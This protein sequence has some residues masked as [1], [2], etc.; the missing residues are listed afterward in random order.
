M[1]GC[2]AAAR[3]CLLSAERDRPGWHFTSDH[4]I[5]QIH[6]SF[7]LPPPASK[8]WPW[9]IDSSK[10]CNS[11]ASVS[12]IRCLRQQAPHRHTVPCALSLPQSLASV[13]QVTIPSRTRTTMTEPPVADTAAAA[14]QAAVGDA[15]KRHPVV[16]V[17]GG[18]WNMPAYFEDDCE[19]RRVSA[20]DCT[21]VG[22]GFQRSP[23]ASTCAYSRA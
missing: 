6:R 9:I 4:H 13:L 5:L 11:A 23:D 17:H 22:W 1:R 12:D 7:P 3:Q 20:R 16:L 18:A 2:H 21:C 14:E 19:W 15:K 8:A 10:S